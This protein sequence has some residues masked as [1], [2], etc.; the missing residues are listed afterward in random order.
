MK[1]IFIN[2]WDKLC[3]LFDYVDNSSL[4]NFLLEKVFFRTKGFY[5]L[6]YTGYL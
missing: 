5:T 2:S 4:G 3:N 1:E 6:I